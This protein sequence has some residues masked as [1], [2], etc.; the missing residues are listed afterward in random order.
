MASRRKEWWVIDGPSQWQ[1][2]V[3]FWESSPDQK[4]LVEFII[5]NPAKPMVKHKLVMEIY[6]MGRGPRQD[7]DLFFSGPAR[8]LLGLHYNPDDELVHYDGSEEISKAKVCRYSFYNCKGR[9]VFSAD[10]AA[11]Y[12]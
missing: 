4:K 11:C 8:L 5:E 3:G 6:V 12:G 10:L 1:L 9:V 2:T 7:T